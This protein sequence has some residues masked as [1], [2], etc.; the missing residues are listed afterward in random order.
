M[1]HKVL[2]VPT[3][4]TRYK[5]TLFPVA[6]NMRTLIALAFC[7]F[8]T[9]QLSI[10]PLRAETTDPVVAKV[11]GAEIHESD[12]ALANEELGAPAAQTDASTRRQNIIGFLIDLKLAAN[13]RQL[14]RSTAFRWI[15]CSP[16]K[17]KPRQPTR[18]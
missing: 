15:R 8:A 13:A 1:R 7:F 6:A 3:A 18:P 4:W 10:Q 14:S 12:V 11:N 5:P 2:L 9:H 17:A 16:G